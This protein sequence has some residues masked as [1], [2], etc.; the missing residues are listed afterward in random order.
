MGQ[1]GSQV[2]EA[3]GFTNLN[4]AATYRF[5][6]NLFAVTTQ[7]FELEATTRAQLAPGLRLDGSVGYTFTR[8][9]VAGDITSQYLSNVARQLV[10]GNLSLAHR[11][12]TLGVGGVYKQ[13]AGQ[14]TTPSATVNDARLTPSYVVINGRLDVALVPGRVW[15]VG[16]AQNLFNEQYSDLLGAQMPGR[17]LMAGVRLALRK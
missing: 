3:T 8:L 16:Q 17:W 10:S 6:Q 14:Q 12:L 11:R 15:A 9:D 4:P 5:A 7:G 1:S 2:I 13:R